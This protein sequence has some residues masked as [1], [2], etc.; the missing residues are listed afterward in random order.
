MLY[1][2]SATCVLQIWATD[3]ERGSYSRM[4]W[5]KTAPQAMAKPLSAVLDSHNKYFIGLDQ[6]ASTILSISAGD[7]FPVMVGDIRLATFTVVVDKKHQYFKGC[8]ELQLAIAACHQDD[9]D[10]HSDDL[11]LQ[12]QVHQ[13]QQQHDNQQQ[14]QHD[15]PQQQQRQQ[16][17]QQRIT[18]VSLVLGDARLPLPMDSLQLQDFIANLG[19][20]DWEVSASAAEH[21]AY[22]VLH[23]EGLSQ[24]QLSSSAAPCLHL[25]SQTCLCKGNSFAP[26]HTIFA[27]LLFQAQNS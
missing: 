24:L 12:L 8:L 20:V 3:V 6:E 27:R 9:I 26:C 25:G 18:H 15:S 7:S 22:Q 16:G 21:S 11:C 2:G 1:I 13:A 5:A 4:G 17:Q 19:R 14:Q 10:Q 23:R